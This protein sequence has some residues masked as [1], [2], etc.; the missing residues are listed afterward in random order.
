MVLDSGTSLHKPK[1]LPHLNEANKNMNFES[2]EAISEIRKVFFG[3]LQFTNS[4]F[5]LKCVQSISDYVFIN[6]GNF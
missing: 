4:S 3:G 2:R 5:V 6:Q 1:W